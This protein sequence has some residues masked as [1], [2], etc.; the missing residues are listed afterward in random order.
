MDRTIDAAVFQ[1]VYRATS[2]RIQSGNF[3][4]V[5]IQP[6]THLVRALDSKWVDTLPGNRMT[7]SAAAGSITIRD[8][9]HNAN[10]FSGKGL[11]N[12]GI[13]SCGAI[14]TSRHATPMINEILYYAQSDSSL[15]DSS[16]GAPNF[17]LTMATK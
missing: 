5:L 4:S 13:P 16:T 8:G 10:R 3:P 6:N 1:A 14:Y 7:R 12:S 11:D 2:A 15:L 17:G 9:N